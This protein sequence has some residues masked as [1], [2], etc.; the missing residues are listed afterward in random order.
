MIPILLIAGAIA[1]LVGGLAWF[2]HAAAKRAEVSVPVD[3]EFITIEGNRLHYVDRGE[4]PPLVL[5]HG[6]GG[7][8]RNFAPALVE[9][10]TRDFRVIL[11]D[12]P[13]SG[14][15]VRAPGAAAG[16]SQQADAVAGFIRAL[17]LGKVMLVGH[18]LGGALSLAVAIEHPDCVGALALIA[19]LTQDQT[20]VPDVFRGLEIRSRLARRLVA[21]TIAVPIAIATWDKALGVVF[22]PEAVP[23]DFG[24]R[25]GGLLAARPGNFYETSSDLV[26]LENRLPELVSHYGAMRIPVSILYGEGDQLLDYRLHG[27]TTAGQIE[28]ARLEVVPG[29]HM[30]PFTQPE[31]T[32]RWI[33]AAAA[34]SGFGAEQAA[35]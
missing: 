12:R 33:R 20:D 22:G 4:G 6:L 8:L 1:L 21:H 28:G 14:Y 3:G 29:G 35:A 7:Q 10:L 11:L 31:M 25:G 2:S 30:L 16:L 34:R 19:P 5:I 15:S 23:D 27:E 26:A 32:A 18:S 24:T 13:G 17:G 9:D